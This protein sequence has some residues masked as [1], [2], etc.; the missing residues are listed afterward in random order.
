LVRLEISGEYR[1]RGCSRLPLLLVRRW[2]PIQESSVVVIQRTFSPINPDR[3]FCRFWFEDMLCDAD[4]NDLTAEA[5]IRQIQK[6]YP[7][8]NLTELVVWKDG[9]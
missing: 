3:R 6:E 8:E 9:L 2:I 4:L 1:L 7:M 5:L